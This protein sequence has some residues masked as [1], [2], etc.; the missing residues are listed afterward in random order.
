MNLNRLKTH[1]ELCVALIEIPHRMTCVILTLGKGISLVVSAQIFANRH[2]LIWECTKKA[3]EFLPSWITQIRQVCWTRGR[4]SKKM[5]HYV[6]EILHKNYCPRISQ[7]KKMDHH[8]RDV[9]KKKHC[10]KHSIRFGNLPNSAC[11]YFPVI[12][13]FRTNGIKVRYVLKTVS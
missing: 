4:R 5:D 9:L 12:F 7:A 6:Q 8:V 11:T 2:H 13:P 3:P 10:P 1:S